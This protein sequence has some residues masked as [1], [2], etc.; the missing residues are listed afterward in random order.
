[1]R[2]RVNKGGDMTLE[3]YYKRCA[4]V[5]TEGTRENDSNS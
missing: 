1:M 5:A 3:G 4:E 2:I